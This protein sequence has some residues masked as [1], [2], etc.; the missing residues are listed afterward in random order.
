[1]KQRFQ[2]LQKAVKEANEIIDSSESLEFAAPPLL[3]ALAQALQCHWA[4]FWKVD[5]GLLVLRPIATWSS[6]SVKAEK[7]EN[8]TKKR[9]LSLSE[10]TAGH[11]WRSRMPVWTVDLSKDMCIPRSLDATHAGLTGGIWFALKTDRGVYGVLEFLGTGVPKANE[12]IIVEL[13][14]SGIALG[15]AIERR[16]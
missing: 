15:R 11:V 4:T 14:N 12:E 10:G 7:L 6:P 1:M 13:E 5:S 3:E 16:F 8:D 2:E 9:S